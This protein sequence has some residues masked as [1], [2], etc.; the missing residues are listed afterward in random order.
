MLGVAG[1]DAISI[2]DRSGRVVASIATVDVVIGSL[3]FLPD[4][5][6]LVGTTE[7]LGPYNPDDG[8]VLVWDWRTGGELARIEVEAWNVVPHGDGDR[9]VLAPHQE[10]QS[11]DVIVWDLGAARAVTNI[12]GHSG[13]VSVVPADPTGTRIATAGGD[14]SLRLW[15]ASNGDQLL[16]L[17]GHLGAVSWASFDATGTRLVSTGVDGRVRVW[18]LD[19]NELVSI[20]EDRVTRGLTADECMTYLRTLDHPRC[21]SG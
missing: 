15:H 7:S 13:Q 20:A 11:Q 5:E 12:E 10:P 17:R 18:A 2:I 3:A 8:A 6:R 9:L 21:P 16:D 4:G 19:R 14:G 1:E